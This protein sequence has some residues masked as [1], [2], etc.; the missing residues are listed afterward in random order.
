MSNIKF[1][2]PYGRTKALISQT[3][4]KNILGQAI[5]QLT[6]LFGLMYFGKSHKFLKKD[7][8]II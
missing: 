7:Y 5:Y 6:I 3:M 2:L 1:T 8:Q 4:W